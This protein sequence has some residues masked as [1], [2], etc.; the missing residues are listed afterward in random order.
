MYISNDVGHITISNVYLNRM[1]FRG[2]PK[3]LF[4]HDSSKIEY[5]EI[6]LLMTQL[7]QIG[8]SHIRYTENKLKC[9]L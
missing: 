4:V 1:V 3:Y 6:P 9:S 2:I 5:K 7:Y 8:K